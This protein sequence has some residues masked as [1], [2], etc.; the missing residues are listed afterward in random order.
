MGIRRGAYESA[1]RSNITAPAQMSA[2]V[3]SINAGAGMAAMAGAMRHKAEAEKA[4]YNVKPIFDA[5][6]RVVMAYDNVKD[7]QYERMMASAK[8]MKRYQRQVE[9]G[10][11]QFNPKDWVALKTSFDTRMATYESFGISQV[12]E[13][14]KSENEAVKEFMEETTPEV[15]ESFH[16]RFKAEERAK[17]VAEEAAMR[18][19]T[20]FSNAEGMED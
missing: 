7:A 2:H 9:A 20:D 6:Q 4:K 17:A 13:K 15:R 12:V 14:P 5:L 10:E 8:A 3:P 18:H 19:D 16:K 11:I 1:K